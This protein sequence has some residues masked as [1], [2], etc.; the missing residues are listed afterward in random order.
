[1]CGIN[2][3]LSK[4]QWSFEVKSN[5]DR[6]NDAIRHRGPDDNGTFISDN[7]ALGHVRLAIIDLSER[8]HQPMMSHDNRYVIIYNGEIY[9]FK[10]IKNQLKDYPFRSNTDTEVILAAYLHW[11]KDC[12][13]H[14]NGMF[15]FAIYDTV[16]KTTFIARDRL[17]IK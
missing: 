3:I 10:E 8:G 11:G 1:M 17:G 12:L 4:Y 6:M 13:H 9:N 16:E 2:G 7:I 15:A 5:I 14:L